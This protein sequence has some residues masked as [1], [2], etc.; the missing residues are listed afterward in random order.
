MFDWVLSSKH[1]CS[2]KIF[3]QAQEGEHHII[4]LKLM[5]AVNA[6][7]PNMAAFPI[8]IAILLFPFC[9]GF[10]GGSK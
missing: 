7:E 9:Q 3:K 5:D 8:V 2:N 10:S 1:V 4:V 6:G